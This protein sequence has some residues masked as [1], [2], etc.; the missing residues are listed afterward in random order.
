MIILGIRDSGFFTPVKSV[1]WSL[2]ASENVDV[3]KKTVS[4][5]AP[6]SS[7]GK[8]TDGMVTPVN[9]QDVISGPTC[10][11]FMRGMGS[12]CEPQEK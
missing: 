6:T 12:V 11:F 2:N 10:R 1:V 5:N 4:G 8:W 7:F 3:A 9:L